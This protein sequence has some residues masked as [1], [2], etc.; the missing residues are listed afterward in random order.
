MQEFSTFLVEEGKRDK[1]ITTYVNEVKKFQEWYI[2]SFG[3]YEQKNVS[4]LDVRDYVQYLKTTAKNKRGGKLSPITVSKKIESL[5]TY[6]RFLKGKGI[7][8]ENPVEKVKLPK[9]QNRAE[10]PRW[11]TRNEKNKLVRYLNETNGNRLRIRNKAICF[12]M[13][14]VGFRISEVVA[15]EVS[16][17][18]FKKQIVE[19]EGKGGKYRRVEMNKDAINAIKDWLEVRPEGETSQMFISQKGSI[20]SDGIQHIFRTLRKQTE[21]LELT[22]HTLRHTFGHDLAEKGFSIQLIA[23]LMGHTDI[24][25]TRIYVRPDSKERRGAV[26]SI[27]SQIEE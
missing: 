23:D 19:I 7:I 24:N 3:S 26:N 15:L 4:V 1:T 25:T 22:P 5:R 27:S 11:L 12:M 18:D 14:H 13:L 6:F 16:D 10:D 8:L 21:I 2:G 17:V 9:V 20:T